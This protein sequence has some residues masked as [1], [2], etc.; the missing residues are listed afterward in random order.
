[1]S[2]LEQLQVALTTSS[3]Q[4][5][6]SELQIGEE[7]GKGAFGVVFKGKWRGANV[8]VYFFL[9]TRFEVAIK[10]VKDLSTKEMLDFISEAGFSDSLT[11]KLMKLQLL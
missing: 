7:I 9:I 11:P 8:C 5:E 6:Y 2:Q 1:M 3:E 10:Q 4:I